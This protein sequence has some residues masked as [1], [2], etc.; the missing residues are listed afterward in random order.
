MIKNQWTEA[1][2]VKEEFPLNTKVKVNWPGTLSHNSCGKVNSYHW[3]RDDWTGLSSVH[4]H[5]MLDIP[6]ANVTGCIFLPRY[7]DKV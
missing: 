6:I 1:R 3:V 7:F 5:V 2:E 4:L